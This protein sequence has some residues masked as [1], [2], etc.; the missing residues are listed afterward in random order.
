LQVGEPTKLPGP[1]TMLAVAVPAA[2]VPLI[3]LTVIVRTWFVPTA[4]V[5][6]GGEIWMFASTHVFWFAMSWLP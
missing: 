6:V 4:F 5:A 3:A 2:S 1:L